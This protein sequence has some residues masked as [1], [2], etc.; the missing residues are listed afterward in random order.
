MFIKLPT[1]VVFTNPQ[2][3]I[4]DEFALT[5]NFGGRHAEHR[6]DG[7]EPRLVN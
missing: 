2:L 4:H 1:V 5:M 7:G 3:L 6:Y